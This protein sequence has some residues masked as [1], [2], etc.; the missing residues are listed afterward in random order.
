M[1]TAVS[2]PDKLFA[3]AEKL[4]KRLKKSRSKL[5][6][7]A[8][9]AYTARYDEDAITEAINRAYEEP[10]PELDAFASEASRRVLE[11]VEW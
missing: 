4:A 1:K 5:Y 3:D 11:Q 8:L 9:A 6:A 10:D 2:I 7:E